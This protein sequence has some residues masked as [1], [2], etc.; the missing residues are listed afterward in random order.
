[1]KAKKVLF[2]LPRILAII[3]ILFIS[4]FSLD[5]FSTSDP[6]WKELIGFLIHLVP[7]YLL[8]GLLILSWKYK[9]IG[10]ILYVVL[11]IIFT[12]FFDT[13]EHIFSFLFIS[14]PVLIIGLLFIYS[15]YCK[16][17]KQI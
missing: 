6:F 2:W 3:F 7:I 4:L 12:I 14:L 11:A 15:Y 9:R 1:M 8:I 10:G 13:Y 5:S 16:R 17:K